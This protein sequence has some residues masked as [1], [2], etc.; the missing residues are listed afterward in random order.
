MPRARA[1]WN[2]YLTAASTVRV[3]P[4][5]RRENDVPSAEQYEAYA[6]ECLRLAQTGSDPARK[7][8]MLEMAQA[9]RKL[10]DEL[11]NK[12]LLS[13]HPPEND[14]GSTPT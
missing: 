12:T 5:R 14:S 7:A 3:K 11:K 4:L 1:F 2:R 8:F 6:L 9:W 13:R 10:A